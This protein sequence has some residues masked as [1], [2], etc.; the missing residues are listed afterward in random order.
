MEFN[1]RFWIILI[2]VIVLLIVSLYYKFGEGFDSL[3]DDDDEK[4]DSKKVVKS[5]EKMQKTILGE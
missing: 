3:D 5:I 2:I 1:R 4:F